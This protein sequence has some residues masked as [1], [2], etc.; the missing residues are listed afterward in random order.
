MESFESELKKLNPDIL[1]IQYR[2]SDVYKYI[3]TFSEYNM[4]WLDFNLSF[5]V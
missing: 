1:N 5:Y 2:V 3:D 4:L